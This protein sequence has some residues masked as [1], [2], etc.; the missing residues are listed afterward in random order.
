MRLSRTDPAELARL[1]ALQRAGGAPVRRLHP[2]GGLDVPATT[3][4]GRPPYTK[5]LGLRF[6]DQ[7]A[8]AFAPKPEALA[9]LVYIAAGTQDISGQAPLIVTR[10]RGFGLEIARRYRSRRQALAFQ[11]MLDRLQAW[12]LIAWSRA[13]RL[14][15]IAVSGEVARL[16]PLAGKLA[17]DALRRAP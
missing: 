3:A 12:D 1:A 13:G 4:G 14:I 17:G 5:R 15:Q 11:F 16:L 6:L 8:G 2:S 10:T 7:T 9:A